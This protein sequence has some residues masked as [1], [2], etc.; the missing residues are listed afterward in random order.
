MMS[1][2]SGFQPNMDVDEDELPNVISLYSYRAGR[3]TVTKSGSNWGSEEI[4]P[5]CICYKGTR[6]PRWPSSPPSLPL[7]NNSGI[8]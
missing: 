4:E 7:S 2:S 1:S 8:R 6:D 3:K 5:F